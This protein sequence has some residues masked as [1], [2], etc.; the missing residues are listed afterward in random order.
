M[1]PHRRPFGE[2][3]LSPVRAVRELG[4]AGVF[5]ETSEPPTRSQLVKRISQSVEFAAEPWTEKGT[6][7]ARRQSV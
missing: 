2:K 5:D 7:L 3:G 4:S 1:Y 6:K